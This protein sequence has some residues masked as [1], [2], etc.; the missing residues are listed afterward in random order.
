[1]LDCSSAAYSV[2]GDRLGPQRP[3]L[4]RPRTIP[5]SDAPPR[6]T[7]AVKT[8]RAATGPNR[9]ETKLRLSLLGP[10]SIIHVCHF[11]MIPDWIYFGLEAN[12]L[13]FPQPKFKCRAQEAEKMKCGEYNGVHNLFIFLYIISAKINYLLT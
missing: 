13:F 2:V 7:S 5:P 4:I 8:R 9:T 11:H 10:S 12:I 6:R 1:V 3:I